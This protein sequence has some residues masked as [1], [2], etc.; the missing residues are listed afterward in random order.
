MES[1]LL[2]IRAELMKDV[3]PGERFSPRLPPQCW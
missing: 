2:L 1:D 3:M